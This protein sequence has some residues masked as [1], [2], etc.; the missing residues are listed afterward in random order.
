M[1]SGLG[2]SA[3]F[4]KGMEMSSCG[5]PLG[6]NCL[7]DSP[8]INRLGDARGDTLGDTRRI[9]LSIEMRTVCC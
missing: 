9:S 8:I 2:L 5:P 3:R 4:I 1:S 6:E 7:L